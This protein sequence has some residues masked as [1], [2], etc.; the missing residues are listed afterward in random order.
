MESCLACDRATA[1]FEELA[2]GKVVPDI[3]IP[4]RAWGEC[5]DEESLPVSICPPEPVPDSLVLEEIESMPDPLELS[6]SEEDPP[7]P[8]LMGLAPEPMPDMPCLNECQDEPVKAPCQDDPVKA[9]CQ[10]DPVKAQCSAV[11][12]PRV[13]EPGPRRSPSSYQHFPLPPESDPVSRL[14]NRLASLEARVVDCDQAQVRFGIL[15]EQFVQRTDGSNQQITRGLA[16]QVRAL[17]DSK[18]TINALVSVV[19][20]DA[21][22]AAI[23]ESLQ[24]KQ[25]QFGGGRVFHPRDDCGRGNREDNYG[26]KKF[27]DNSG[28]TENFSQHGGRRGRR[29]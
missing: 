10:D 7:L 26:Q 16:S 15:F 8:C 22:R 5:S 19:G 24:Q 1:D 12:P 20:A 18:K 14:S 17:D 28:W 9:P 25:Q 11:K 23:Q 6:R 3:S 29:R 4:V 13:V 2:D 21:V 27:S